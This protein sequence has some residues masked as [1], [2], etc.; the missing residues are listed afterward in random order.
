M[1]TSDQYSS[2]RENEEIEEDNEIAERCPS[3]FRRGYFPKGEI[4]DGCAGIDDYREMCRYCEKTNYSNDT[5]MCDA[6]ATII[7]QSNQ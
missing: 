4:C 6:C 5:S 7:K 2:D 3:C 1:S